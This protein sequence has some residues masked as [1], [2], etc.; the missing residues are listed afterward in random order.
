MSSAL[1]TPGVRP[2]GTHNRAR[3]GQSDRSRPRP[4]R[5]I[6]T[7][8]VTAV[9][10]AILTPVWLTTTK[11]QAA[12]ASSTTSAPTA[13]DTS[14]LSPESSAVDDNGGS[15]PVA[16]PTSAAGASSPV[17]APPAVPPAGQAYLGAF[18]DP[19]GAGLTKADPTGEVANGAQRRYGPPNVRSELTQL[20]GFDQ[21]LGRPLSIVPVYQDWD[22]PVLT[23]QLDQI[24]ADGSIPLITWSCDT[25]GKAFNSTDGR[26]T[27]SLVVLPATSSNKFVGPI[28]DQIK[29][30]ASQLA[31][32]GAP[33]L[34]RWFPDPNDTASDTPDSAANAEACLGKG[35]AAGGA[36][37]Y[38]SA[39]EEIHTLFQKAGATN[40]GFVWSIDTAHGTPAD[41][42]SY[43]PADTGTTR[44]V[45]W[46][47]ADSYSP[48]S[49]TEGFQAWYQ[50]FS[51]STYG[52]RPLI[53]TS[54]ATPA[55]SQ[56]SYF[57][58]LA[59]LGQEFPAVRGL[60]YFDAP[61]T[62]TTQ[63]D[64]LAAKTGLADFV[65]LSKQ[66]AFLPDLG[67]H[68]TAKVVRRRHLVRS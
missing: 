26:G 46:I 65:A 4:R 57:Q 53:I 40:V 9:V 18:V 67:M 58:Q 12:V 24:I 14:D 48:A 8:A 16:N 59:Q 50:Q 47:G 42:T 1:H 39:F 33:V 37:D 52:G 2:H 21:A 64:E 49:L 22:S 38:V 62:V 34:L 45:D 43:F 28:K 6:A 13:T 23:T 55:G 19:S 15:S 41:W 25:S 44:Y 68:T 54:T 61:D 60:V 56:H 27:D 20:Q 5:W 3:S 17:S 66:S 29:Q 30:F 10:L 7:L 31:S 63:K 51:S 32:F 11:A 35:K 36:A